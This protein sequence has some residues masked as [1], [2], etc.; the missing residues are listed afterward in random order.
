MKRFTHFGEMVM[1]FMKQHNLSQKD[2]AA[3]LSVDPSRVSRLVRQRIALPVTV[4]TFM[5]LW[6]IFGDDFA[7]AYYSMVETERER[8]G[9]PI[10]PRT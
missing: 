7:D 1:H 10:K 3:R 4:P 9:K 6:E 5:D 2:L 8:N